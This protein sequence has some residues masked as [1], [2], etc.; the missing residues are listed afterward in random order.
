MAYF[1]KNL[2]SFDDS[3]FALS[4]Q[5]EIL[6]ICTLTTTVAIFSISHITRITSQRHIALFEQKNSHWIVKILVF[7]FL[8]SDAGWFWR[9]SQFFVFFLGLNGGGGPLA[10]NVPKLLIK[11]YRVSQECPRKTTSRHVLICFHHVEVVSFPLKYSI[12]YYSI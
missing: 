3:I 7:G 9:V 8:I 11:K 2:G 10:R 6:K 5:L 12:F 4:T 1:S